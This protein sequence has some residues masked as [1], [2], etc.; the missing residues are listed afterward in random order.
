M[1]HVV[2]LHLDIGVVNHQA[3]LAFE[4]RSGWIYRVFGLPY[5]RAGGPSPEWESLTPNGIAGTGRRQEFEL[6]S[7]S[8]EAGRLIRLTAEPSP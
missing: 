8:I 4:T 2:P 6:P 5:S 1:L 3:I 7:G